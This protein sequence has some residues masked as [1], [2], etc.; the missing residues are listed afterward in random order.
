M[1]IEKRIDLLD[2]IIKQVNYSNE[3]QLIFIKDQHLG[4]HFEFL[5][6]RYNKYETIYS[7]DTFEQYYNT[8]FICKLAA[9]KWFIT[10][11]L[12]QDIIKD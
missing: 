12:E 1:K 3:F 8:E 9:I 11:I 7:S 4:Y 5:V 2:E 6:E 10:N